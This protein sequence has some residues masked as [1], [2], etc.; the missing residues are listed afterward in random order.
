MVRKASEH[1]RRPD[2]RETWYRLL[3]WDKGQTPAERLAALILSS[4]GFRN[5]DPSHPLGGKDGLKDMVLSYQAKKWIGAVYFPRG[6]QD[7]AE[8][9]K[10]FLHD[11]EGINQNGANGIAFVTNQELRL[12]E[13]KELAEINTGIDVQIYHLERI[14][15]ILN[16]P[17]NYG[18]RM[19]FLDIEMTKE[20]QLA[21]FAN[22]SQKISGIEATLERLT[23]GLEEYKLMHQLAVQTNKER[24]VDNFEYYEDEPRSIEEIV[25]ASEEFLDKIWFDRHLTLK[26]RIE[27][28]KETVDPEIWK[29]ALQSAQR[30][31]EQ[32][33]EDNLGP[34]SEFEWGM[35]NGKLSALRWV[36][37]D[38]WDMLDT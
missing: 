36:L 29:G 33:G 20:E 30:V 17:T 16:T 18:I 27:T 19:E 5:V 6:Q 28:G 26:Y 15:T 35:L 8:I 37:G 31:I 34:Y 12:G 25:E 11:L 3:E 7:F 38:E 2:G 4:E 9:K 24:T 13:R 32:Y 22:Q 23:V 21:F 14:A 10:K 1:M